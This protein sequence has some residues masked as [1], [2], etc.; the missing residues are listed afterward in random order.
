[1]EI[2]LPLC[3]DHC[4]FQRHASKKAFAFAVGVN[5]SCWRDRAC[6][7]AAY[8]TGGSADIRADGDVSSAENACTAALS[9]RTITKSVTSAP[10]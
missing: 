9:L 8:R 1:M 4:A 6:C 3:S 10:A 2:G 5:S 7:G